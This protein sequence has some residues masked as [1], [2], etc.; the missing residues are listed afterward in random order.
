MR[1][2]S[3]SLVIVATFAHTADS[4]A[5]TGTWR[6]R[7]VDAATAAPLSAANI[8]LGDS[9]TRQVT[10]SAGR[11]SFASVAPGKHAITVL[12]LGYSELTDSV[13]VGIGDT[14]E[15][16]FQLRAIPVS[17][18]EVVIHGKSVQV[19][20]FFEPAY[21]RMAA[22]KGT[23]FTRE[24]IQQWNAK[25]WETLLNRVPGVHANERGVTFTRCQNGLDALRNSVVKSTVQVY[26]DGQRTTIAYSDTGGG[27]L[28][29]LQ[30][31]KPHMIQIMEVYPS[32]GTIPGEFLADSCA[33][34]VI[35]TKRD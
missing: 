11:F 20:K 22:G 10:D 9:K 3:V 30:S 17:L 21:K 12:R 13:V 1:Y 33:V 4:Q 24:D 27:V 2:V 6:G 16:Q 18:A 5:S 31:I 25:D 14:A 23:F 8:E 7:V 29:L 19:P 28:S 34:I 35:W 32:I 15:A 26:I